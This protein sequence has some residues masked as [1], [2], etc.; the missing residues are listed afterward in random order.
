MSESKIREI[1]IAFKCEGDTLVGIVH[2]PTTPANIGVVSIVAGG[3]QYRGGLA[4]TMV[5]T[6]RRLA[7]QGVP[8]MRFDYRGLGDSEG[9][10]LGFEDIAEDL[11]AAVNAFKEAVP[12]VEKIVLWGGCDAASGAMIHG[13]TIPEVTSMVLGNPWVTTPESHSAMLKKHYLGRL[14]EKSFWLKL[15]RFEYNLVEYGRAGTRK[16]LAKMGMVPKEAHFTG[17]K[18]RPGEERYFVNRM[19][20]G[21]R[22]FGGPVLFLMSGQSMW[23]NEFDELISEDSDWRTVY[24]RDTCK[25]M[26]FPDAD[27]TFSD[28][29]SRASAE[30]AIADWVAALSV[31]KVA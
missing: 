14:R 2:T 21:L 17:A 27:Q 31:E 15:V 18:S 16:V 20:E 9:E 30:N 10:F 6:A 8:V 26:D 24:S 4:R 22:N 11:Q 28:E 13:W 12:Q 1:P 23:S 25:R 3:P 5:G 7:V 19:L 29:L